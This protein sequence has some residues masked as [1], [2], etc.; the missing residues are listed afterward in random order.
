MGI[1]SVRPFRALAA[2]MLLAGGISL[3]IAATQTDIAGPPGSGL[4]GTEVVVLANGN[5]VVADPATISPPTT[6]L[7]VGA[8]HLYD[9]NTR[10]L[11]STL[12][13]STA[14]DQVGVN[15]GFELGV[16]A[17][18]NGDFSSAASSRIM[19]RR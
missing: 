3:A 8:V 16:Q 15:S 1:I 13:G 18:P 11:I 12:T 4:F 9:G 6:I 19:A 10:A 7:D 17:L 5:F 14:N 2:A